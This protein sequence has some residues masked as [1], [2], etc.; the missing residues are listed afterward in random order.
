LNF[1]GGTIK[2]TA[3]ISSLIPASTANITLTPTLF[4]SINNSAAIGNAT[5]NFTGGLVFDSNGYN[6]TIANPLLAATGFG[7][8][9]T[10]I[11]V[12]VTGNSGYIGA[13][14]VTFSAPS[15]GGVTASGYALISGGQVTGIVITSPGTYASG[16]TPTITLT[17]GGGSI[18]AFATAALLTAN[19]SGGLTKTGL[20][21]LTLSAV[22]TYSGATIVNGG[23][24]SV[25][26]TALPNTSS[27]HIGS[28]G[29]G[30]F[31]LYAD[32]VGAAMNLAA[33]AS[34]ILG[35][36]T[37]SG[38]LGFQLGTSADSIVL[39][40]TGGLTINAGGGFINAQ[41]LVGFGL[42]SYDVITGANSIA[43]FDDL[44]LGYLPGGYNYG[45]TKNDGT[46]TI[47]LNV[48]S[49]FTNTD[50]L[51][52]TGSNGSS[53]AALIGGANWSTTADG[54]SPAT[55][56]PTAGNVVH[57]SATSVTGAA[58]VV[59][60][61]DSTFSV[62]GVKVLA[63]GAPSLSIAPGLAGSLILGT[64]GID[65]QTG[66]APLTTIS[67]PVTLG[68][69]QTWNITDAGSLLTVSGLISG[70]VTMSPQASPGTNVGLTITG[71]GTVDFTNTGNT[72]TGDILV[73]GATF[74]LNSQRDWGA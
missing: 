8:T 64:D 73:D 31:D 58:P 26:P 18:A 12:P 41:A 1:A 52:W 2:T 45:L 33:N 42:G 19:T 51:Y 54:L 61:V 23:S 67:A 57:F 72:F 70:G 69:A 5:Q 66:A 71:A 3:A 6:S 29:S 21:T 48:L 32:G 65:I 36:A 11:S 63:S 50:N 40:G 7:V 34:I 43:G 68:S 24:L 74:V 30:S 39:S 53:W 9:Q 17:G 28:T 4:G 59:T 10:D 55:H 44:Q 38:A 35:S 60:T 56:T 16:E 25:L 22:N 37:T 14:A 47:T 27:L 62:K 13:P 49:T 15:G 20:G 46:G